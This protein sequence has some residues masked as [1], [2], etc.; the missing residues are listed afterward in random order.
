MT[1]SQ[2]MEQFPLA[3]DVVGSV[4]RFPETKYMGSKQSLLPFIIRSIASLKFG[5]AL[6]AFSGSACVGYA[7]KELGAETHVNDFLHFAYHIGRATIENNSTLLSSADLAQ[8]THKNRKAQTFVRDTFRGL[9]FSDSDNE[10]LDHFWANVQELRSPLKRSLAL[11]AICRAAM[12]KRPRGI[13][14]FTGHKGWDGRRDLK[15]SMETQFL[16]AAA[17]FNAAVFSNGKRNKAF[18]GD[19]FEI[20]PRGYDLVY[21]DTPYVSPYSDCDYTRRYHFVEGFCRY[22]KGVEIPSHT[23]TR[24]IRSYPTAFANKRTAIDAFARLFEH[25]S[26]STLVVSYFSN[27]I[28]SRDQ[29]VELLRSVKRKVVVHEASHRYSHGNQNHKVGNNNNAVTEYLFIAS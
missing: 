1:S 19:V 28:P 3:I 14:T 4:Q 15:L 29:M 11:A 12:K 22:W 8:L 27:G 2:V 24:K 5:R 26:R 21:I 9:Y 13:F 23:Q 18:C 17:Q 16:T 25:F 10:F 6:D 20:D 7:L